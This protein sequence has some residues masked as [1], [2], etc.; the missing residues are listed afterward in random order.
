MDHLFI[1]VLC[2][3][4]REKGHLEHHFFWI[5]SI[6]E[7]KHRAEISLK[8]RKRFGFGQNLCVHSFLINLVLLCNLLFLFYVDDLTSLLSS[9]TQLLL[10][11]SIRETFGD[12]HTTV[13][14]FSGGGNMNF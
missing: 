10:E 3:K 5:N 8:M 6:C 2:K 12:F 11:G 13:S 14:N 1:E 4:F 9:F 7:R